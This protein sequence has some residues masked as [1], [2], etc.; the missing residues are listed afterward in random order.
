LDVRVKGKVVVADDGSDIESLSPGGYVT[1]SERTGAKTITFEARSVNGAI[2]RK[3]TGLSG[4]AERQ[5]W[6][7][8]HLVDLRQR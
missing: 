5:K 1:I 8:S 2:E 7:A 3:W 4:D 6:L